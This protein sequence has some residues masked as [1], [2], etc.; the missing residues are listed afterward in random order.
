M[1]YLKRT[2]FPFVLREPQLRS[3]GGRVASA[4]WAYADPA[5]AVLTVC[6]PLCSAYMHVLAR[7]SLM[8]HFVGA[9]Y[10]IPSTQ[11]TDI[12]CECF[13][14]VA[15]AESLSELPAA[16][17]GLTAHVA[18]SGTMTLTALAF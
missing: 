1:T 9:C 5:T 13:G 3:T 7:C 4:L 8:H 14:A 2:Y 18:D 17:Q 12:S 15:L 10:A 11:G 16:L 6:E